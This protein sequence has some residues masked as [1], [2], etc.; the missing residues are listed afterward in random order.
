V[1]QWRRDYV[2]VAPSAEQENSKVQ[3]DIWAVELPHGM[4]KDSHL[5]PQHSQDLLRAARSGRIYKRPTPVEEEDADPEIVEK[6]E[7]KED[8]NKETGFSARAWK[9]IPR[10][11]EGPDLEYLAKR[12]KGL[13]TYSKPLPPVPTVVKT[14][15]RRTDAAGNQYTQDFVVPHGQQ[16]DGEVVAQ[17]VIP[18]PSLV[19]APETFGVQPT[20]PKRNRPI[21]KK[22][23]KGPGRGRKKKIPLPASV[24]QAVPID[25]VAPVGASASAVGPDG[26]KTEPEDPTKSGNTVNE[27][28]EMGEGSNAA[29]DEEDGDEDGD[30]DDNEN[31]E[32]SVED[33]SSPSKPPRPMSPT[34]ANL[35]TMQTMPD[36]MPTPN[37]PLPANPLIAQLGRETSFEARSG[38]PLKNVALATSALA[39]PMVSP[40][41]TAAPPFPDNSTMSAFAPPTTALAESEAIVEHLHAERAEIDHNMQ[42]EVVESAPTTLPSPPP[43]PTEAELQMSSIVRKEEEEEEMM[44]LDV[45]ENTNAIVGSEIPELPPAPVM[46]HAKL[47]SPIVAA[48]I[49]VPA[50]EAPVVAAVERLQEAI[51]NSEPAPI[52]EVKTEHVPELKN[53]PPLAPSPEVAPEA[54]D[55]DD[56]DFPD[57]LGG[58]EKSLGQPAPHVLLTSAINETPHTETPVGG[59]SALEEEEDKSIRRV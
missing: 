30:E 58:L 24:P 11:Q 2:T 38:S 28:T 48:T 43:A 13:V 7:K 36:T 55:E 33:Q 19:P 17:T 10:Q 54:E 32:G 9:Q 34:L 31:E 51:S 42:I 14:T 8:D 50:V 4:P 22:R 53:D 45:V 23:L 49:E 44:L 56:D 27:D 20:P 25:G 47:R 37:F 26:I 29:S 3:N 39:S 1:R 52:E 35:P 15:V 57:L 18:D 21:Q 46:E 12:R 16:V 41:V 40:S 5:L 59:A 6:Q